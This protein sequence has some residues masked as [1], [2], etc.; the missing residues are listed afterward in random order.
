MNAYTP[1]RK[2]HFFYP[3]NNTITMS[4]IT[5]SFNIAQIPAV[6]KE[7]FM[8]NC[9]RLMADYEVMTQPVPPSP[10]AEMLPMPDA[11][12][13]PQSKPLEEMSGQELRDRL[14][15][16][17]G[18]P[19]GRKTTPK[20]PTKAALMEEILRLEGL[21]QRIV[22]L[23]GNSLQVTVSGERKMSQD[24]LEPAA[25]TA[26]AATGAGDAASVTSSGKP[27]KNPWSSY[28]AEQKTERLAKMMAG[29]EAKKLTAPVAAAGVV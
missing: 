26:A 11:E 28:T 2:L 7:Q 20:F 4:I 22:K 12:P 17:T 15:D 19:H 3:S 23:E 1:P 16:L 24:S 5:I 9:L 27:R 8:A 6:Y 13:E 25:A 29:R 18:K 21:D 14:A 10:P